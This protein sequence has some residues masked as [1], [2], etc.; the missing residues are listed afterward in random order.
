MKIRRERQG[1]IDS[2]TNL[3]RTDGSNPDFV[4]LLSAAR[5]GDWR[6]MCLHGQ[7]R[8][9]SRSYDKSMTQRRAKNDHKGE[10]DFHHCGKRY[11]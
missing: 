9:R 2:V 3:S 4:F 7:F 6:G 10:N 1:A 11:D 8:Q 5:K